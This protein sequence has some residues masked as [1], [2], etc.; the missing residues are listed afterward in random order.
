MG[1]IGD[2]AK[3]ALLRAV[4]GE[5]RLGVAWYL[6]P[7]KGTGGDHIQYLARPDVWRP[8]DC[9]LFD[10][11][12]GIIAAWRAGQPRAVAQ[13]ENCGLLPGA[14]FARERLTYPPNVNQTRERWRHGWFNRVMNK[15]GDRNIVFVDPD[16]GL[17]HLNHNNFD[18]AGGNDS[19][20][21]LP[22]NEANRLCDGRPAVIYHHL[23]RELEHC[24]QILYWMG[25]LP[26]CTHAFR[27][28]RW[29]ARAFFVINFD[30]PMLDR[31]NKFVERWRAAERRIR[32][33]V[34][35]SRLYP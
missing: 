1:D 14:R 12:Q 29:N 33:R 19:W 2:Y 32:P 11:L 16:N 20:Q 30:Q 13:I 17:C 5:R 24:D 22:L 7:D 15:L 31:L 25:Q 3:Y 21:R 8:V 18:Y 35:L 10:S 23:N 26:G 34:E 28:R 6:H 4:V 9:G 27:M